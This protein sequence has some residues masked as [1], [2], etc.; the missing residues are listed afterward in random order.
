MAFEKGYNSGKRSH[1]HAFF[2]GVYVRKITIMN[3]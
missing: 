1:K 3:N 2:G